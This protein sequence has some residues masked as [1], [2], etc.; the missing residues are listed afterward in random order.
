[1]IIFTGGFSTETNTFSP[2]PTTL[3]H[4]EQLLR[5]SSSEM[6]DKATREYAGAINQLEAG[7]REGRWTVRWGP[8][9]V[10]QPGGPTTAETYHVLKEELLASLAN[11]LPVDAVILNLHGAMVA[12]GELDCEGDIIR[13]VRAIAGPR[14]LIG[15]L[16]DPH[17]H[18]TDRMVE[19]SDL[20]VCLKEYPHTDVEDCSAHLCS[21]I[22]DMFRKQFRPSVHVSDAGLISVFHTTEEPVKSLVDEMRALEADPSILSVSLVHGFPFGDVHDMGSKVLVYTRGDSSLA[23]ATA[24]ELTSEVKSVATAFQKKLVPIDTVLGLMKHR[25]APCRPA[26]L[27]DTADNPGGGAPS[28]ATYLLQALIRE[29]L[30]NVAAGYIWDPLAVA[31]AFDAGVKSRMRMRIRGKASPLS[32]EPLDLD[33]EIHAL[34]DEFSIFFAGLNWQLGRIACLRSGTLDLLVTENRI[35]CFSPLPFE[36]LGIDLAGKDI[37]LVKSSQHFRAAFEEI[38]GQI[39]YVN[40]AGVL[41]HDFASLPYRRVRRPIWPLDSCIG[42]GAE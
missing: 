17:C 19:N 32:G 11:S 28:D 27:A 42:A 21:C 8:M 10:A 13:S 41:N 4:F 15:V 2:F 5:A 3:R 24:D 12:D 26:I 34:R 33:V 22:E 6:A 37:V 7:E 14:T 31:A 36:A 18:M 9:A 25:R 39:H 35:Q 16:L 23:Q 20:I 38:G 29:G 40:A 30:T 1:M